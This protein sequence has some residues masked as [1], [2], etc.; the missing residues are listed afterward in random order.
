MRE[1]NESS[2]SLSPRQQEAIELFALGHTDAEVAEQLGVTR[3]TVI[4][5]RL[6]EPE[7]AAALNRKRA[8]IRSEGV[9]EPVAAEH[10]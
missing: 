1:S 7:F 5:W 10:S 9:R 3:I 8:E 6:Y 2:Q 4:D